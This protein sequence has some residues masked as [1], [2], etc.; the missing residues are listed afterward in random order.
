MS[1]KQKKVTK[2]GIW[3]S[4]NRI[5]TKANPHSVKWKLYAKRDLKQNKT[6]QTLKVYVG[7]EL[8][9]FSEARYCKP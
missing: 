5:I 8:L 6:K 2:D 4:N 3:P 7:V 9:F 1:N